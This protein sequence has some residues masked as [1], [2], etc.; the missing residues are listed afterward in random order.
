M[1]YLQTHSNSRIPSGER[2]RSATTHHEPRLYDSQ[3]R[4][5]RVLAFSVHRKCET[6]CQGA[7]EYS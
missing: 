2:Q 6:L 3:P 7:E 1:T 4:H 5:Y